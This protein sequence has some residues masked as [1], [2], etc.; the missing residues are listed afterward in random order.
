MKS[1]QFSRYLLSLLCI[2]PPENHSNKWILFRNRLFG[3]LTALHLFL[4]GI[5]AAA[6]A[7]KYL[8]VDFESALYAFPECVAVSMSN[9]TFIMG[10][11]SRQ[12]VREMFDLLQGIYDTCESLQ[13]SITEHS[14][15]NFISAHGQIRKPM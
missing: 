5:A 6:A 11:I 2:Y 4:A 9:Y 12:E 10:F 1:L 13:Y 15:S 7:Y 8:V 14:I 3:I